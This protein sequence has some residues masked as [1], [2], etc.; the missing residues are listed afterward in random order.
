MKMPLKPAWLEVRRQSVKWIIIHHTAEMYD[1]PSARIDTA[2]YQ[3]PALTKGVMEKK[4]GDINYH[5]VIEKVKDDY[6]PIACRP[7]SYLCEWPDIDNNINNRA[8]HVALL[9][10]YDFKIPEKRCYEILAY[11]LLNPMLKLF[12]IS[13]AKIKLHNEVSNN[14]ELTCPGEFIDKAVIISMTRKFVIK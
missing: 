4:Q 12:S 5:Y 7:I 6:I 10:S 3:Y 9:G 2:T 8:V 13:P 1:M 11:K 14:K